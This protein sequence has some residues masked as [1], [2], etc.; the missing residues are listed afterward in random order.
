MS[1]NIFKSIVI[2]GLSF[3]LAIMLVKPIGVSTEYSTTA[4]IIEKTFD[5]TIVS[6]KKD[7]KIETSNKYYQDNPKIANNIEHPLSYSMLFVASIPFGALLASLIFKKKSQLST[8]K[9]DNHILNNPLVLFLGGFLLLFGARWAGRC[10]SGHMMQS[11]TS[12]IVF[13]L[14]VSFTGIIIAV[15]TAKLA[16]KDHKK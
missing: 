4:G 12:G 10:T 2:L 8:T 9:N 3:V 13:A 11:S 5:P 7:G 6:K 15:L 14:A 1:K 16:R